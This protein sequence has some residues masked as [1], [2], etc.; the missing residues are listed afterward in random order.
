MVQTF[1]IVL[2]NSFDNA[3]SYSISRIPITDHVSTGPRQCWRQI[4]S[5]VMVFPKLLWTKQIS[6]KF[7]WADNIVQKGWRC[8]VST[9]QIVF[10]YVITHL[11]T[12]IPGWYGYCTVP[13][14]NSRPIIQHQYRAISVSSWKFYQ[15]LLLAPTPATPIP[16]PQLF[17]I[18]DWP[19]RMQLGSLMT[20]SALHKKMASTS[21]ISRTK[22][23]QLNVSRF[24]LQLSLPNPLKLGVKSWM[25]M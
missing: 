12:N 18:R 3:S 21:N 6:N 17:Y 1:N 16:H 23:K 24:V 5:S 11:Y 7:H 22:S 13:K 19:C 9:W 20:Q 15:L 2:N 25:K 4:F 8:Y 14:T 10:L